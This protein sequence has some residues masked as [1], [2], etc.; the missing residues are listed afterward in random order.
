M[1]GPGV[2]WAECGVVPWMGCDCAPFAL[3]GQTAA[4]LF[5]RV[6]IPDRISSAWSFP[7]LRT[8]PVS[9]QREGLIGQLGYDERCGPLQLAHRGGHSQP[10]FPQTGVW[11]SVVWAVLAQVPHLGWFVQSSSR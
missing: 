1:G 7:T 5:H 4:N 9:R 10:S 3:H 2:P 11:S 8:L 6:F